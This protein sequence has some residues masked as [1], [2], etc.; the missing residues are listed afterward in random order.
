VRPT[1]RELAW[2]LASWLGWVFVAG[3]I[4]GPWDT[5]FGGGDHWS[6]LGCAELF[7]HHGFGLWD[8]LPNAYCTGKLPPAETAAFL[9]ETGCQEFELCKLPDHPELRP[10]CVNWQWLSPQAYPPGLILY[11][12]PQAWLYQ[13]TRLS[14]HALNVLTIWEYLAA[15]H[16]LLFALYRLLF[17]PRWRDDLPGGAQWEPGSGWLRLGLFGLLY[18]F[19]I[20]FTLNGFYDPLAVF[21]VFVGIYQLAKRR[22]VDSLLW[23]SAA[24]FL[25][26]RAL[27]YAPLLA[28]AGL[29]ALPVLWASPRRYAFKFALS[30]AMLLLFAYSLF[31]IYP[32][33]R[34]FPDTNPV[35]LKHASLWATKEWDLLFPLAGVFLY[36]AWGRH[37]LVLVTMLWQLAIVSTTPQIM[38]WHALFLLPML[39]VARL[40]E[41]RGVM[42]AAVVFF[43]VEAYVIFNAL[44]FPGDLIAA[45]AAQW[46]P[47]SIR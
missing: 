12:L 45:I 35:A 39:G 4:K 14:F 31:L 44:P 9:K 2:L 32:F 6:H 22:P 21:A 13:H 34:G 11:S 25:H 38:D 33:L 47:F 43:L 23:L 30:S 18:F 37:W 28:V 7:L 40:D 27:W 26:Y 42:L 10:F 5:L 41:D 15:A 3:H 1:R 8:H 16:L 20:K 46:G 36:L 17:A 19:V 29:R 24:F